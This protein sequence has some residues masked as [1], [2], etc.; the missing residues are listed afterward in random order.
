[1]K[2]N[3]SIEKICC[4][5]AS[6]WHLAVMLLPFISK[7]LKENNKVYMKFQDS[8]EDKIHQLL[9]KLELKNRAD[10]ERIS[11]NL[12]VG[13][14]DLSDSNKIYIVS[15]DDEYIK[16]MNRKIEQY[17]NNKEEKIQIIDCF[18]IVENASL[19]E[20]GK[21]KRYKKVL[22]TNGEHDI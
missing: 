14:E 11:W 8:I 9:E 16:H 3:N 10:I 12:E 6:D 17:Y 1:M 13:E 2:F 22:T 19:M 18:H 20:K 5:Y 4:I 21:E 7:S 15:G